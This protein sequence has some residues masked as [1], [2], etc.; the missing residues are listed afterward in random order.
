MKRVTFTDVNLF[1]VFCHPN[2]KEKDKEKRMTEGKNNDSKQTVVLDV[3]G[4]IKALND[5]K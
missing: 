2:S 5:T 4:R 3:R 1:I